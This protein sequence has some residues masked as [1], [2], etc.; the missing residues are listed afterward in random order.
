MLNYR[1]TLLLFVVALAAIIVLDYY[2][3]VSGWAYPGIIF[4]F[5]C[6][7][8]WGSKSI[9]SD[10]YIK[11]FSTGNRTSGQI[12]L[13][14]DDG[15][16]SQVTPLI[17]DVLKKHNVKACFFIIGKKAGINPDLLKR[18]DREGHL[19]GSH[20]Y[21]HHFFFDLFPWQRMNEEMK[22]TENIVYSVI[23]KKI[24]M[25]RPPYGVTNPPLA[26]AIK[27]RNYYSIGWSLKSNDTVI[28]NDSLILKR[29]NKK[30]KSGD[31]VLLHDTKPWNVKMLDQFLDELKDRNLVVTRL[32]KILNLQAYAY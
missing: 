12:A 10:Y 7:L 23:G 9:R 11:S 32:D 22:E 31:I 25:F 8:T 1:N 15:P 3:S 24:K 5:I 14:F 30:V 20:S 21:T 17:L 27:R 29:L 2:F 6:L 16:D 13:T 18:M 4:A 28:E 19:I 26:K